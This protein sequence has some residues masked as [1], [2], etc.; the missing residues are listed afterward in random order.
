LIANGLL[1]HIKAENLYKTTEKGRKFMRLYTHMDELT[2][3]FQEQR[4]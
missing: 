2:G 1:E 4:I 3:P